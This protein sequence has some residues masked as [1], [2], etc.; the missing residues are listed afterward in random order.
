MRIGL[1]GGAGTVDAMVDQAVKA[2]QAGFTSL[3]Y[4]SAIGGDPLVA[5]A[6]AGRATRS[7]ELGTSVLQTYTSH[8]VLM[9][10]RVASV[11]AAM[12]RP[13]FTLGLGPSHRPPIEDAYGLSY[14]HP[15]RHTEEYVRVLSSLL[16]DGTADFDG[17]DF[18]LHTGGRGATPDHPVPVLLAALAPRMLRVAGELTDGTILWMGNAR[19]I[20]THVAPR[21]RDAAARAGRPEPRIVAGLPVAVHDDPAEARAAAAGLFAGYGTLPNYRRLLDIGGAEG[22]DS[23]AIVGDEAAVTAGIQGL[24]DAGATDVWAAVF[25]VGDDH[26]ASRARTMGLLYDLAIED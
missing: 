18:Q 5:M 13:G 12:R 26:R 15:G 1:S 16:A 14:D 8:P 2:E 6:L 19:A 7:I 10:N 3:W 21:I 24:F 22:P 17:Q 11:S 4:A 9:A 23:A 25:P 20:E